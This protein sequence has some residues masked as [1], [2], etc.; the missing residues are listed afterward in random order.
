MGGFRVRPDGGDC[1]SYI[2]FDFL[3]RQVGHLATDFVQDLR[4]SF[5]FGDEPSILID[6]DD[7]HHRTAR[8][9]DDD[10]LTAIVNLADQMGEAM[11]CFTRANG[12]GHENTS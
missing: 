4:A 12:F 11:T 9:L 2:P 7:S 8:A 1:F 5:A 6:G 3:D 10:D